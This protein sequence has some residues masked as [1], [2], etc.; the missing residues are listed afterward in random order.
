MS[1]YQSYWRCSYCRGY[2]CFQTEP[3]VVLKCLKC[4]GDHELCDVC[5]NFM[6]ESNY[7]SMVGPEG[8]GLRECPTAEL[9]TMLALTLEKSENTNLSDGTAKDRIQ[10]I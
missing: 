8:T 1:D 5:A 2:L 6:I 7:V 10:I 3:K 9:R 4:R